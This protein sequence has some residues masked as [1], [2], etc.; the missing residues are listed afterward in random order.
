MD[1]VQNRPTLRDFSLVWRL[2]LYAAA[3]HLLHLEFSECGA[4]SHCRARP[5]LCRAREMQGLL[6]ATLFFKKRQRLLGLTACSAVAEVVVVVGA[7]PTVPKVL[8][9]QPLVP[10]PLLL[11][12][13]QR[14]TLLLASWFCLLEKQKQKAPRPYQKLTYPSVYHSSSAGGTAC[15]LSKRLSSVIFLLVPELFST[16]GFYGLLEKKG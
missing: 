14:A 9:Q 16:E 12:E 10:Q 3:R 15:L 7:Q 11:S 5:S 13:G 1:Y 2:L 6:T 8:L 4:A